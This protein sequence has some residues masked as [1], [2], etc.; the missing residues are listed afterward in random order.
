VVTKAAVESA[1]PKT[2]R[3]I[4]KVGVQKIRGGKKKGRGGGR[5]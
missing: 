5:E 4:S 3:H 1:H 2:E